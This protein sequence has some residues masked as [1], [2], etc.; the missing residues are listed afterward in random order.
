MKNPL[1]TSCIDGLFWKFSADN[2]QI[3]NIQLYLDE[4]Y[5]EFVS[6]EE[7]K[8]ILEAYKIFLEYYQKNIKA[9]DELQTINKMKIQYKEILDKFKDEKKFYYGTKFTRD[10]K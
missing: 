4:P 5:Y 9:K 8:P 10:Q 7:N 1:F 3:E 2:E 6:S